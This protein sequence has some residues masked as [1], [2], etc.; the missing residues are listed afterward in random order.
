M[1][2]V[3]LELRH[4]VFQGIVRLFHTA[5]LSLPLRN[6]V[7][8]PLRGSLQSSLSEF[9]IFS[10]V[11]SLRSCVHSLSIIKRVS[12][13]DQRAAPPP[14][15]ALRSHLFAASFTQHTL[16]DPFSSP[17]MFSFRTMNKRVSKPISLPGPLIA[18]PLLLCWRLHSARRYICIAS[19]RATLRKWEGKQ[20]NRTISGD[21]EPLSSRRL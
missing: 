7:K 18:S 14:S 4:S 8:L 15:C 16:S 9:S 20:I 13:W 5:C 6:V 21:I 2:R 12:C 1:T 19:D 11:R 17:K 3:A 10:T